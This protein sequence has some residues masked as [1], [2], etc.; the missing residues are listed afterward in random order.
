[1]GAIPCLN[2]R[3]ALD[4]EQKAETEMEQQQQQE[5]EGGEQEAKR[6]MFP[7]AKISTLAE[8]K[9][10]KSISVEEFRDY[11]KTLFELKEVKLKKFNSW[12]DKRIYQKQQLEKTKKETIAKSK[13]LEK[14]SL[15]DGLKLITIPIIEMQKHNETQEDTAFNRKVTKKSK[16]EWILNPK[17]KSPVCILHE[18]L[19]QSIKKPPEYNYKEI[20]SS[21]TPYRYRNCTSTSPLQSTELLLKIFFPPL[22]LFAKKCKL[23]IDIFIS[24]KRNSISPK[25]HTLLLSKQPSKVFGDHRIF[26]ETELHFPEKN[27]TETFF[28]R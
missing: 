17:G 23:L 2:Y 14:P 22:K 21:S 6:P 20:D 8:T 24:G 28:P 15:P 11:C 1:M 13:T 5:E 19:Q 25:L 18:Y 27:K 9:K 16:R 3:K 26:F 12:K 7:R 4:E 10:R